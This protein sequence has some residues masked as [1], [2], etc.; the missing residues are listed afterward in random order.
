MNYMDQDQAYLRFGS[1]PNPSSLVRKLDRRNTERLRNRDKLLT[2]EGGMGVSE[3]LNHTTAR[4]D[5]PL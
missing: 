5:F 2:G 3:E 1:K 4:K